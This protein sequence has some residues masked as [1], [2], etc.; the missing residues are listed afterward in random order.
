MTGSPI[1][2]LFEVLPE[3]AKLD[4]HRYLPSSHHPRQNRYLQPVWV[5][6]GLPIKQLVRHFEKVGGHWRV[7]PA[8]REDVKFEQLNLLK[9]VS[10][11]GEF[12]AIFCR[13]VLIY[14]QTDGRHNV[15]DQISKALPPDGTLYLGG[16]EISPA[17][18]MH[19]QRWVT[20]AVCITR[21]RSNL[22][23]RPPDLPKRPRSA[24]G[25][26]PVAPLPIR[27]WQACGEC[28]IRSFAHSRC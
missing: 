12:D 21:S 7:K 26:R 15:L 1:A 17:F 5:Q 9:D 24:G 2:L 25:R 28:P 16:S 11:L 22:K 18:P 6:R 27:S 20:H 4:W 3:Q 23:Y 10:P 14:F 8:L 13:N 19:L